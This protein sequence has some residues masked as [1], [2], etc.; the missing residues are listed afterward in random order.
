[1]ANSAFAANETAVSIDV[2]YT[3]T[4][5]NGNGVWT[6]AQT[7]AWSIFQSDGT[8]PAV[9][10]TE[11]VATLGTTITNTI[12]WKAAGTFKVSVVATDVNGCKTDPI[13]LTI[14]VSA[15]K[16]CISAAT[17]LTTCSLL[18][19]GSGNSV[20]PDVTTFDITITNPKTSG[21]YTVNYTV[22][23]VAG[24]ATVTAVV[25]GTTKTATITI[26][27]SGFVAQFTNATNAAV[28][29]AIAIASVTNNSA[30]AVTSDCVNATPYNVSVQP[31]PVATFN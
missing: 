25:A 23:G 28:P 9:V 24:S 5:T 19:A 31:K 21:T 15:E 12:T 6:G 7:Y 29:V 3:Y 1:M 2:P 30:T 22:G 10:T 18:T 4:L 20:N 14:T 11:Y 16:Y 17:N 26:S 13:V 8:T 27:H